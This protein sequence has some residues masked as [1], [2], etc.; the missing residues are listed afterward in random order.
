MSQKYTKKKCLTKF[1]TR[2]P[3][4]GRFCFTCISRRSRAA[5]PVKWSYWNLK[6]NAKRRGKEFDLTFEQFK[7]FCLETN[8]IAGKGRT[9]LS[10]S[11][12]RIDNTKGYTVD[13]IRVVTVTENS[14]KGTKVLDY[15]WQTKRAYVSTHRREEALDDW[16]DSYVKPEDN[17]KNHF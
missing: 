5:N 15:D 11:I 14:R 3:S 7:Q 2:C 1:C 10:Y 13:N 4:R 17:V 6:A 16:F 12:D 8:Y 9:L